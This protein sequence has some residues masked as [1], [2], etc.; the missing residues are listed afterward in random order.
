MGQLVFSWVDQVI[1]E[2]PQW[3]FRDAQQL[4]YGRWK[5]S[6]QTGFPYASWMLNDSYEKS[7]PYV[8]MQ[9]CVSQRCQGLVYVTQVDNSY[10]YSWKNKA[11]Y[12]YD[13]TWLQNLRYYQF[14]FQQADDKMLF[15]MQFA[16]WLTQPVTCLPEHEKFY[17]EKAP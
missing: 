6:I 9:E 10:R 4:N 13:D 3:F 12:T 16:E 2:H 5:Y 11:Y 14:N 15:D 7:P 8:D 1:R 17:R